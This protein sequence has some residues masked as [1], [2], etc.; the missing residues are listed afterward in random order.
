MIFQRKGWRYGANIKNRD[1]LSERG[2]FED[3]VEEIRALLRITDSSKIKF[4]IQ[5]KDEKYKDDDPLLKILQCKRPAWWIQLDQTVLDK[6]FNG[7]VGIRAQ[8]YVSPYHGQKMNQ[9]LL[10]KLLEDLIQIAPKQE[11]QQHG[12]DAGFLEMSLSQSSAKAWI[13]ENNLKGEKII[14]AGGPF[15]DESIQNDWLDMARDVKNGVY[16]DECQLYYAAVN[17]V[18]APVPDQLEIKGAWLTGTKRLE[19]VT[20]GKRDRHLQV[21]MFGFS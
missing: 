18:Q 12:V 20:P 5:P 6:F 21:F 19:Y 2:T 14:L 11:L 1:Y 13:S 10:S 7:M 8:Y 4:A 9:Y 3:L 15:D 16:N 17:G